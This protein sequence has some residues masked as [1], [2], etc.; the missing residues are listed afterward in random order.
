MTSDGFERVESR[1]YRG[2]LWYEWHRLKWIHYTFYG[3]VAML[4]A[5]G[6][7]FFTPLSGFVGFLYGIAAGAKA[8][9]EVRADEFF[10]ALPPRRKDLFYARLAMGL[11]PQLILYVLY[12]LLHVSRIPIA[13]SN[14]FLISFDPTFPE[15]SKAIPQMLYSFTF[16]VMLFCVVFVVSINRRGVWRSWDSLLLLL[17]FPLPQLL[18]YP[19]STLN[20]VYSVFINIALS[21]LAL[22]VGYIIFI[23]KE[24]GV[25]S[26]VF[27]TLIP[28]VLKKILYTAIV[29]FITMLI[30][31]VATQKPDVSMQIMTLAVPFF[32]LAGVY[33]IIRSIY[34]QMKERTLK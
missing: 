31:T 14:V 22:Y 17:F 8:G 20:S 15:L 25:E 23:H 28:L 32:I 10:F 30:V 27:S 6:F 1:M 3:I 19:L 13:I 12:A 24:A 34:V 33:A 29:F 18:F 11:I 5:T 7:L 9:D 2:L 16:S 4:T 26:Y 21:S